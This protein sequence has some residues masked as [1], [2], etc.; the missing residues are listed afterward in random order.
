MKQKI[1]K[2][3][4]ITIAL[5]LFS[6]NLVF[7]GTGLTMIFVDYLPEYL[8]WFL[9]GL[10]GT[11]ANLF[12]IHLLSNDY[13]IKYFFLGEKFNHK[14]E[15]YFKNTNNMPDY[16]KNALLKSMKRQY[17]ITGEIVSVY[18]DKK[19][20]PFDLWCEINCEF[21]YPNALD[22]QK[23]H[24]LVYCMF[25]NCEDG[26]GLYR[27]FEDLASEPFTYEE[28][29]K[30]ISKTKLVS[31]ELKSL[32]LTKQYETIFNLMKVEEMNEQE[33]KI[34]QDFD[35]NHSDLLFDFS[36]ELHDI[37]EKLSVETYLE[38][39]R[40]KH[41]PETA[42]KV[43][44]SKDNTKRI[45]VFYDEGLNV[46]RVEISTFNFYDENISLMNCEGS[47]MVQDNKS[48]YASVELAC[49]DIKDELVGLKEL[50]INQKLL[51]GGM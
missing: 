7:F 1:I 48:Y 23:L 17:R 19:E 36:N 18:I 37:V 27:F 51:K 47:W 24:Y 31:K 34:M 8:W 3:I 21:N 25:L 44:I 38:E 35:E 15:E 9:I 50:K 42:E 16:A 33:M 10:V 13:K 6:T 49:A 22:K 41:L 30:L 32:L 29:C 46:Y 12:W 4:L 45:C 14:I 5:L 40:F 20:T 11:A 28:F 2:N 26:G 43:F 39:N